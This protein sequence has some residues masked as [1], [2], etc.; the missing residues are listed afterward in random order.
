MSEGQF[1]GVDCDYMYKYY[2]NGEK[3]DVFISY[4]IINF[5][6]LLNQLYIHNV[7]LE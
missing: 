1:V 2:I 3:F 5:N 4:Q 7:I 6:H